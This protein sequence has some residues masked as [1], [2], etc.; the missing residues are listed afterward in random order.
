[1]TNI[2]NYPTGGTQGYTPIS[3]DVQ[4][5][6]LGSTVQDKRSI[7]TLSRSEQEAIMAL[8]LAS[9][10]TLS[11]PNMT[12]LVGD[13][14]AGAVAAMS[15]ETQM[16]RIALDVVDAWAKNLEEIKKR[17]DEELKSPAYQAMLERQSAD[18]K[19]RMEM[20][21][22]ENISK[23]QGSI[24]SYLDAKDGSP[25]A[26]GLMAIMSS[27][28]GQADTAVSPFQKMWQM[29]GVGF[30]DKFT[31]QLGMIG[32]LFSA[33]LEQFSTAERVSVAMSKT[34]AHVK[35]SEVAQDYAASV[36]TL[37]SSSEFHDFLK[38][39]VIARLRGGE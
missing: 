30:N 15:V 36:I 23:L 29:M 3:E 4:T 13:A 35:D 6:S 1:M 18:F 5:P 9:S 24:A 33:A 21:S 16:S 31:A 10:P 12:L 11:Q 37:V 14:N 7:S 20:L 22:P 25:A 26:I 19:A 28:I 17:R 27:G 34:N 38:N 8:L 32:G 39:H 2:S